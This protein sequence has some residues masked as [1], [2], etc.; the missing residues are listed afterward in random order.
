MRNCQLQTLPCR[1]TRIDK[2]RANVVHYMG[3]GKRPL[4][5][6]TEYPIRGHGGIGRLGGFRF[7]CE[8]VQVRVLL[9]AP[10]QNNPN[11]IFPVG[12]GFG[13]FVVFGRFGETHFRNGVI[14]RPE[15]KP[16][17]PR[18][19]KQISQGSVMERKKGVENRS[20]EN[21]RR[22][23]WSLRCDWQQ[24]ANRQHCYGADQLIRLIMKAQLRV[25]TR[26]VPCDTHTTHTV[27]LYSFFTPP[28]S[29]PRID[30]PELRWRGCQSRRLQFA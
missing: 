7:H 2:C 25:S 9:P 15:S 18:K 24:R 19:K 4:R 8:S 26:T 28:S 10:N 22:T 21:H 11:Q 12:G 3:T 17:G 30:I 6:P 20:S 23:H 13:L 16:R 5:F 29:V 1:R 27:I 14:K